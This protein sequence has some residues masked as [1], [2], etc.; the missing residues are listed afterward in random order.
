MHSTE[1]RIRWN[2]GISWAVANTRITEVLVSVIL[3]FVFVVYGR[4]KQPWYLAREYTCNHGHCLIQTFWPLPIQTKTMDLSMRLWGINLTNSV[5]IPQSFVLRS[6]VLGWI[7]MYQNWS[8]YW[9]KLIEA[10]RTDYNY[11]KNT[12]N[13]DWTSPQICQF[14]LRRSYGLKSHLKQER[15]FQFLTWYWCNVAPK[16]RSLFEMSFRK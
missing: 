15:I 16:R 12:M 7:L 6:I 5:V 8:V 10:V 13:Y 3:F 11:D 9:T 4:H 1:L 2:A 14:E